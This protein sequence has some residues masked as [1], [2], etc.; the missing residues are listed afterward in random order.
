MS[1]LVNPDEVKVV[2]ASEGCCP[3][4]GGTAASPE[5]LLLKCKTKGCPAKGRWLEFADGQFHYDV[6]PPE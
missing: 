2:R 6:D 4:C 1:L 3:L 5:T